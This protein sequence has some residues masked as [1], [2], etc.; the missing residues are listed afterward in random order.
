MWELRRLTSLWASTACYRDSFSFN[1]CKTKILNLGSRLPAEIRTEHISNTSLQRCRYTNQLGRHRVVSYNF[2]D[3]SEE[4]NASIISVE[5]F[6][7]LATCSQGLDAKSECSTFLRNVG[8]I[9]SE[10]AGSHSRRHHCSYMSRLFT[11]GV[12]V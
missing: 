6:T 5:D 7:L 11:L 12:E 4:S 1:T 9:L 2:T 3:V 10:D 8:K